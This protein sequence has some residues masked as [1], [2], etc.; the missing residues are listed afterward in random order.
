MCCYYDE[1]LCKSAWSKAWKCIMNESYCK[2][3]RSVQFLQKPFSEILGEFLVNFRYMW[4]PLFCCNGSKRIKISAKLY[5]IVFYKIFK[6]FYKIFIKYELTNEGEL[7]RKLPKMFA[8]KNLRVTQKSFTLWF[9]Q[10]RPD[11]VC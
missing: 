7:N 5:Q 6:R 2:S 4:H 1:R 9:D 10:K 3:F 11:V 8:G